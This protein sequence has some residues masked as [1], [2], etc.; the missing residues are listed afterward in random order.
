MPPSQFSC[1][2]HYTFNLLFKSICYLLCA[3]NSKTYLVATDYTPLGQLSTLIMHEIEFKQTKESERGK[4]HI[5]Q[6]AKQLQ[7][8]V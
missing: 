7:M 2:I 8:P 1:S 3:L 4:G 6:Y 5:C